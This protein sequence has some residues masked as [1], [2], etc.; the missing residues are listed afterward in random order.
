MGKKTRQHVVRYKPKRRGALPVGL[1]L[2]IKSMNEGSCARG[3]SDS[4][5]R[6]W[7]WPE[8]RP[9]P[10]QTPKTPWQGRGRERA[11]GWMNEWMNDWMKVSEMTVSSWHQ[12]HAVVWGKRKPW[13]SVTVPRKSRS[14]PPE[15][16]AARASAASSGDHAAFLR[17]NARGK[18]GKISGRVHFRW[19]APSPMTS[20]A[21]TVF[22]NFW[23]WLVCYELFTCCFM[24][25]F[26]I[27]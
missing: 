2:M 26:F 19:R 25:I 1:F 6:I 4:L 9:L 20:A 15:G 7:Y 16:A 10:P 18:P 17:N 5:P 12:S 23:S 24:L 3:C 21:A 13:W 11:Q 27:S 22:G 8:R 14:S